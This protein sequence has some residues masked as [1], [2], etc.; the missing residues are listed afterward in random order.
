MVFYDGECILCNKSIHWIIRR[1]RKEKFLFS[2]LQST[3]AKEYLQSFMDEFPD[4]VLLLNPSKTKVYIAS[5][6]FLMIMKQLGFPH[7]L[8]YVLRF[9]PR[10]LRNAL[11][12]FIAKRRF[13]WFGRQDYCS[14]PKDLDRNRFILP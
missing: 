6:A 12:F 7:C 4:V 10:F 11:Y 8:W 2:T 14:I 1:D 5:D 3:T 9:I 13:K